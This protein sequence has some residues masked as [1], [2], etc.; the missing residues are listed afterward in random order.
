MSAFLQEYGKMIVII[1]VVAALIGVAIYFASA[2]R[3]DKTNSEESLNSFLDGG[4]HN[5]DAADPSWNE[6]WED[7]MKTDR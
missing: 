1:I 3:A 2:A 6:D 7:Y 4:K 5:V